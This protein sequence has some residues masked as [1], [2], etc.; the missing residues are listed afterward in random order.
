MTREVFE[1]M[2]RFESVNL[3]FGFEKFFG[4]SCLAVLSEV[5]GADATSCRVRHGLGEDVV[6]L[7]GDGR[8]IHIGAAV[9][10][11]VVAFDTLP[12]IGLEIEDRLLQPQR[13]GVVDGGLRADEKTDFV[14]QLDGVASEPV[15]DAGVIVVESPEGLGYG[16][17]MGPSGED[18]GN[19]LGQ[20]EALEFIQEPFKETGAKAH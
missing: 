16:A 3:V 6:F 8:D 4:Q 11:T 1:Q 19:A 17:A 2:S 13:F 9:Q 15:F 7:L 5:G 20:S 14:V 12:Q 18:L 10:K